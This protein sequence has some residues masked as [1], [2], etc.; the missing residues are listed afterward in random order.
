[1]DIDAIGLRMEKSLIQFRVVLHP[2]SRKSLKARAYIVRTMFTPLSF[3]SHVMDSFKVKVIQIAD[4]FSIAHI[5][6]EEYVAVMQY[7]IFQ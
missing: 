1:M 4:G 3:P 7:S 5:D 2:A 6:G